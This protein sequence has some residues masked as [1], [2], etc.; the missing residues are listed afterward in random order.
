MHS[1][2]LLDRTEYFYHL[3]KRYKRAKAGDRIIL[4]TMEFRPDL[5]Q[6]SNLVDAMCIASQNGARV[7][8]LVDAFSFMLKDGS[9]LG[10][11]FFSQRDPK[12]G[13]GH[14]KHT[15]RAVNKLREA[16]VETVVIN[17]PTRPLKN[18]FSGR[19]HIKFAVINND[20]FI[21]GCNLSHPELLDVMVQTTNKKLAAYME[22]FSQLLIEHKNVRKA[23]EKQD[24]VFKVDK[25]TTLLIDAG[26]KRQ[27]IIYEHA[28]KLINSAQKQI[29]MTCQYFPN[30]HTPNELAKAT[31]RGVSVHLAYNHPHKHKVP[32]RSIQKQTV[33][34]KRLRLPL[35]MFENQLDEDKNYL[36][37]KILLSE[38]EVIVGS[39]NFVALGVRLGTAE[40]A[41]HSTSP[42]F[43]AASR[44]WV[45]GI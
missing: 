35:S 37:A 34:Y 2:K 28:F 11:L 38:K 44:E 30:N 45:Q 20:V 32:L 3:I 25:Y 23:L 40:I 17:K 6:L 21:G 43:I 29:F 31:E 24:A 22:D 13:Y 9:V 5:E 15:I 8:F 12:V 14:F 18:P 33:A 1:Y 7:T 41:L 36:H 42:Q 27:S 10:P 4:S 19:S 26:V 16:G 39:H